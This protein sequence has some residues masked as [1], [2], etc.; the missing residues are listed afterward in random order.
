[1]DYIS[2]LIR[3]YAE[4]QSIEM[5]NTFRIVNIR[6]VNNETKIIFQI[7][8]KAMFLESTPTEII[9]NDDFLEKFSK[10]DI[11]KISFLYAQNENKINPGLKILRQEYNVSNE[12]I[13]FILR[14]NDGNTSKKTASQIFLDKTTIAKL[15]PEQASNIGFAAGYEHSYDDGRIIL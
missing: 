10:K 3:K 2:L 12:K 8:G 14:D 4:I 9:A 6:T 7:I 1:M 5:S 15:S 11:K 13:Q